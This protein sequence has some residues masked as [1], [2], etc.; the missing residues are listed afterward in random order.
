MGKSKEVIYSPLEGNLQVIAGCEDETGTI[1]IAGDPKGLKSLAR[2]LI[3][4]AE[5]DQTQ[6]PSLPEM[7]ASEHIHLQPDTHLGK[8]SLPLVVSRLDD[9]NGKFDETFQK[10][11]KPSASPFIHL[12]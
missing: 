2:L 11:T 10:A 3:E 9:K 4:L 6:L 12:W 1:Y 8:G 5:V 7:G